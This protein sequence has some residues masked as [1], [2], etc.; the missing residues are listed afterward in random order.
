MNE[1]KVPIHTG[2]RSDPAYSRA[3]RV[4][5]GGVTRATVERDPVPR[6]VSRAEGPYLYDVDNRRFLDLNNN[7]TTLIHGHAFPPVNGAIERQL[8]DGTCFAN[9]TDSEI[10][11]AE[12]LCGRVPRL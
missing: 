6:Y 2:A 7:F 12:L 4:F 3:Q 1:N 10:A 9:P 11:L 8:R 5:P